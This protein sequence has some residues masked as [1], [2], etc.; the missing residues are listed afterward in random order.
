MEAARL[1]KRKSLVGLIGVGRRENA[2]SGSSAAAA[3]SPNA[4]RCIP[5]TAASATSGWTRI[6]AVMNIGDRPHEVITILGIPAGNRGFHSQR[7]R[8]AHTFQGR[9]FKTRPLIS[10]DLS[11]HG[12]PVTGGCSVCPDASAQNSALRAY[13]ASLPWPRH[14]LASLPDRSRIPALWK[15]RVAGRDR[16]TPPR[17]GR[18]ADC[19]P[20]AE[21]SQQRTQIQSAPNAPPR[22]AIGATA[23]DFR[24]QRSCAAAS[25]LFDRF[26]YGPP[27]CFTKLAR[28]S[29]C[30]TRTPL[31]CRFTKRRA[32]TSL[33]RIVTGPGPGTA[34][35]GVQSLP[36]RSRWADRA[37]C[38]APPREHRAID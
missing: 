38:A 29:S 25:S 33:I 1:A 4:R 7:C 8:G 22:R 16:L 2:R 20:T 30:L 11:Q 36:R 10:Q 9:L 24:K 12:H 3:R 23:A 32:L 21:A 13:S 31:C 18:T 14:R 35:A 5:E 37:R 6:D 19:S 15:T 28:R 26:T 34:S 27:D 17:R